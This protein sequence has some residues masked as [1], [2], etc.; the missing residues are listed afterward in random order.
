MLPLG[1]IVAYSALETERLAELV[2]GVGGGACALAALALVSRRPGLLGVAFAGV[3]AAYA[4]FV[5]LRSDV[6]D[7]NAP[8]VAVGLFAGAELG[9]WA[10][11]PRLYL[12][13]RRIAFTALG[14]LGAGLAGSLVLVASPGG[15][16]GVGIEALGVAAAVALVALVAWLAARALRST[17]T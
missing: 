1:A 6:V 11:E 13:P 5:A 12:E 16:G 10:I 9:F 15:G 8:L 14:A 3:G 17:S 2:A 4:I 7:A